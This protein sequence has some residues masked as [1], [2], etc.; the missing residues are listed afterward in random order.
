MSTTTK[1]LTLLL[2]AATIILS[3]GCENNEQPENN[4]AVSISLERNNIVVGGE[5]S[6]LMIPYT[7]T[8]PQ[9]GVSVVAECEESW[10][11]NIV[12]YDKIISCTI[13]P[14][15]VRELRT[16]RIKLTYPN[17]NA[18]ASIF[19]EQEEMILDRI[20]ITT[21]N[22]THNCCDLIF[23]PVDSELR[24]VSNII[25]IEYFT[26]SGISDEQ[27]FIDEELKYMTTVAQ[28][29][30]ITLE[31]Y[32]TKAGLL[33]TGP[34]TKYCSNLVPGSKY[35]V[36]AYGLDIDGNEYTMTVPI[37]HI[38]LSMPMPELHDISFA[39]NATNTGEQMRF[40]ITPDSWDGYYTVQVV[41]PGSIY[42]V[43]PGEQIPSTVVKALNTTFFTQARTA[44]AQ[45]IDAESYMEKHC[46]RGKSHVNVAVESGLRY[47]MVIFAVKSDDGLVPVMYSM[48][49]IQYFSK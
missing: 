3:I 48:P 42:Y 44:M 28:S 37:H 7:V 14:S 47:M 9:A 39:V 20:A 22:L 33:S 31:E 23:T 26:S 34:I 8:N 2:T 43:E 16:A 10:V 38:V 27:T 46:Y 18:G 4:G 32:L 35:V 25:A 12:V 1:L 24:Y 15:D 41:S 45:G 13:L 49:Q 36:Y 40:N 11:T 21:G 17:S 5:G 19:I 6:D 30:N 29:M